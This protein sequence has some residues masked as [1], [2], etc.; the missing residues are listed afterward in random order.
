VA[1]VGDDHRAGQNTTPTWTSQTSSPSLPEVP[2]EE[3]D[4]LVMFIDANR[5]G[6]VPFGRAHPVHL[7]PT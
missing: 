6:T 1:I 2:Q 4:G 3:K 5:G 7:D